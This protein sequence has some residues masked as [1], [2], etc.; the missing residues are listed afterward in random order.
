LAT[1]PLHIPDMP[2]HEALLPWL[3]QI[4]ANRWY[5]NFGPLLK[6]FEAALLR[7]L[8]PRCARPLS[9]LTT[10]SGTSAIA[11]A[12]R[13][14]ELPPDSPVL[15]PSLTFSGTALAIMNAGL[16]PVFA[17]VDRHACLLTPAIACAALEKHTIAAVVPVAAFGLRQDAAGWDQF[18]QETG[19]PIVMDAAGAMGDQAIGTRIHIAFSLHATKVISAGEGGLVVSADPD[20]LE[21]LRSY[22]YFGL[23]GQTVAYQGDNQKL[24]EY[25][26]AVGLASLARWPEKKAALHALRQHYLAQLPGF[27]WPEGNAQSTSAICCTIL[28]ERL[29]ANNVIAALREKAIE[30][31]QWYLPAL[32]THPLWQH[33]P[34]V[35]DLPHTQWLQTQLLGLPFHPFLSA[36]D[37]QRVVQALLTL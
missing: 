1:I 8:Q 11:L 15:V 33:S 30:T 2:T 13:G 32:H 20:Y 31:K 24:S 29:T 27:S 22:A 34:R 36:E 3:K 7:F 16:R 35:D 12:L 10:Q 5:S 28:P 23:K 19:L 18:Q 17:D 26:A 4:D 21:R 14:L 25:A 6:Q 9:L 37:K